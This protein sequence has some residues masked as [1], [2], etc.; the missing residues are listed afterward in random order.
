[1]DWPMILLGLLLGS[2]FGAALCWA[3]TRTK[4]NDAAAAL[5][6]SQRSL[7]AAEGRLDEIERR[8]TDDHDAVQ[9]R[10]SLLELLHPVRQGVTDMHRRIQELERERSAQHSQL[11]HQLES[12]AQADATIIK[13]TQ[14]LLGS[15]HSTSARGYWGEV[16]LRRVV[17]AAGMLPHVDFTEQHTGTGLDGEVLR[18]DMLVQLPGG[19][20]LVIDAKAPLHAEDAELQAKALRARVDEL[21]RKRYWEAVELS[22]DVVFCFLPA[23]SLL[24]AA[25]EADSDLLDRSLAKGVTLVSPSSLLAAM[26]AVET[27][28][29]QERLAAN[30]KEVVDNSRELYRR[31]ATMSSHLSEV[32][33]RLTQSVAAY[34]KLIG[35]IE[36]RVLPQAEALGRLEVGE[37]SKGRLEDLGETLKAERINAEATPLGPRLSEDDGPPK[38]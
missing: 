34:N 25:L 5:N 9:E 18:P 27:A 30:I 22:P 3:L 16:Q 8:R 29:R 24:S 28:W 12:A 2:V 20:H 33:S 31:L 26:K 7:A 37:T 21:S 32:G 1:M 10:E 38:P 35:N 11:S 23:E 15:L 4:Y 36:R 13:S 19:R 14:A 6:E 17:E